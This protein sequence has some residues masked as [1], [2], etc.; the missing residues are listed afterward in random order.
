M[1][2]KDLKIKFYYTDREF[3]KSVNKVDQF[4]LENHV[5]SSL[6]FHD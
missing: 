1:F 6:C 5:C 2:K 4:C 3:K